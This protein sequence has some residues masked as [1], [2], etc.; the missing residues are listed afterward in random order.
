MQHFERECESVIAGV[1]KRFLK[2][3]ANYILAFS[4][5]KIVCVQAI[6][7]FFPLGVATTNLHNFARIFVVLVLWL[8]PLLMA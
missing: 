2:F 3:A 8:D 4:G 6:V 5:A 1:F 7:I